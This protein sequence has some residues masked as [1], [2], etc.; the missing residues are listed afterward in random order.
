[1]LWTGGS[2]G[3]L[4]EAWGSSGTL[5]KYSPT[6]PMTR[7]TLMYPLEDMETAMIGVCVCVCVCVRVR[8]RES[9]YVCLFVIA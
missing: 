7:W 3:S 4:Y 8:E 9:L 1:M 5:V 2:P 6:T